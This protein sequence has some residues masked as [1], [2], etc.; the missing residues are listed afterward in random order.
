MTDNYRVA[1][2]PVPASQTAGMGTA[3]LTSHN[4][5]A[6]VS[7]PSSW[8]VSPSSASL[9]PVAAAVTIG[10]GLAT[11][12]SALIKTVKAEAGRPQTGEPLTIAR[13]VFA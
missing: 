8:S 1:V 13:P 12:S 3:G 4:S 7:L 10:L 9:E 11:A 2:Y 6:L 5:L